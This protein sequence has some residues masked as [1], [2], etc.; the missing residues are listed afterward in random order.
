MGPPDIEP[1]QST[2]NTKRKSFPWLSSVPVGM[3]SE[4]SHLARKR[5]LLIFKYSLMPPSIQKIICYLQIELQELFNLQQTIGHLKSF[6]RRNHHIFC[7][8]IKH[9]K[10]SKDKEYK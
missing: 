1:L 10:F 6:V 9:F 7:Q 5:F 3:S 4:I 8:N 2:K